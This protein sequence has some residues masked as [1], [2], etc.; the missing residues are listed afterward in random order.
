MR[1]DGLA[2]YTVV[3]PALLSGA[4]VFPGSGGGEILV[5]GRLMDRR[6]GPVAHAEVEVRLAG[7]YGLSFLDQAS[8]VP[9][10]AAV[11]KTCTDAD[12][13]F[14]GTMPV[15]YHAG[16]WVLPPLGF[17][18]QRPPAPAL[19]VRSSRLG[20]SFVLVHPDDR[21]I[22]L[23]DP[24]DGRELPTNSSFAAMIDYTEREVSMADG[25][26]ATGVTFIITI[27]PSAALSE[28]HN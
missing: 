9:A 4:C 14:E 17:R 25:C 21:R 19:F 1:T 18:P 26:K 8:G 24:K 2:V 13:R 16:F 12:G 3:L 27:G 23:F 11:I 15:I 6:A 22:R 7:D 10:S 28:P 20:D 5:A